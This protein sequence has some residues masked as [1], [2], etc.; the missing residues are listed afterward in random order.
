M[1]APATHRFRHVDGIFD[2]IVDLPTKEQAEFLDREVGGD[3]VLRGEVLELLRAYHHSGSFLESPAAD[4][5]A[6]LLEAASAMGGPAPDQI[7][8]FRVVREI[9]RGGMGRVF[10]G[11]RADGQF[12]QRVAIK[13]IQHGTPGVVRRFVEERRILALLE[14]PNIA[15]LVDGGI[16]PGGLPY[17]AME[18]IEG[19]PIDRYCQSRNLT[20][21]ARLALVARVCD[22]VTYAHQHLIIHR[23]LKPSNILVTADGQVKLLDFGIAK[24]MIAGPADDVTRTEFSVMT[25][26]FAAPEQIRGTAISTATDVYSLGVLLYLL[27]TGERPYDVRGKSPAEIER[28]V[29]IEVPPKPSSKAPGALGRRWRC[30]LDLIVM[31]ALQKDP[32]RRYQSPAALAQDLQRLRRGQPITAR[33]DST[34]YRVQKYVGRHRAGVAVAA[35][36]VLG[37]AGAAGRERVL[38]NRAETQARRAIEVEEFLVRVFDVADP[39]SWTEPEGGKITARELL[40]RGATRIDSTL[41]EQPEV[42]AKLRTVLGRV[43]A[44]LGLYDQA[45][46]LLRRSLAQQTAMHGPE[47]ASVAE[48]MD[49]LGI[50]LTRL[51]KFDEAEPLLHRALE[52]QRRVY[53]NTH[54]ATAETLEHLATLFEERNE[55]AK[56]EPVHREVLAIRQAL[57]GDTSVEVANAMSNLGLILQRRGVLAEAES[58]HRQALDIK[59]RRLGEEHPLTSATMQNLAMTLASRLKFAEAETYHRRALA[60]KRKALGDAHPSVTISMNNLANLLGR[61]LGR[62]DE[63][64]ALSREALA[65][66]R[67]MFGEQH[68]FV[69]ASLTNLGVTLRMKGDFVAADSILRHALAI[70][71]K[72]FPEP[73]ERIAMGLSAIA[74]SRFAM[75]DGKAAI[76]FMRAALAQ[77]RPLLGDDHRNTITT[78]CNL[79]FMLAEFGD[80]VE[81]ESLSRAAL[82]RLDSTKREHRNSFYSG[83]L[84][85]GKALLAQ[86]RSEEAVPL[87]AEVVELAKQEFGDGNARTGDALLTYGRALA[88]KG[89]YAD[90]APTLKAARTVLEKNR[91]AQPRLIARADAALSAL[92]R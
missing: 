28:I 14:H 29:G 9:G 55:Y 15:R 80:P 81:A 86:G 16:T 17:F 27:L 34:H 56:A 87:L 82:A 25:P 37:M 58:L 35:V 66:D 49:L 24:L 8:P 79:A 53:G 32:Q 65:L 20:L 72:V 5:A 90:A 41:T 10:L 36:L 92:P 60:A 19:E 39:N 26:E 62:L 7:G 12:E 1:T 44:N 52:Q 38:R 73:H 30:D 31:T 45:V 75:G 83:K 71:R 89:R 33:P 70:N 47:A 76:E 74:Q 63:A 3:E 67:K 59:I 77:Y 4:I 46:P 2:A 42:Q 68:S 13:L 18:L 11:E 21:D 69:A 22:A 84:G 85:L 57:H 40:A 48:T 50:A 43:Y 78:I 23:D 88:A 6:P 61:Q 54:A 64:E 51:D 91:R